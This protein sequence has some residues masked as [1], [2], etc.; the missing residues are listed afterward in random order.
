MSNETT[1]TLDAAPIKD[2]PA[3]FSGVVDSDNDTHP[4]DFILRSGDGVD[5]HVRKDMLQ[6]LSDF[7]QGMF[8]MPK[9]NDPDEIRRDEKIVLL[10]P[11]SAKILYALLWIAY[12]RQTWSRNPLNE[13]DID[14]IADV[15]AAAN[16]YQF[17]VTER[18]VKEML[19]GP[20]LLDAH[21]HRL[22]AIARLRGLSGLAQKAAL[23]TLR[24]PVSVYPLAFPE[25]DLLPWSTGRK[26]YD[27]HR[28]CGEAASQQVKKAALTRSLGSAE[29]K[30]YLTTNDETGNLFIWWTSCSLNFDPQDVHGANLSTAQ[31]EA[32]KIGPTERALI[33]GCN[34]CSN[35]ADNDLVNFARQLAKDIEASNIDLFERLF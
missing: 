6:I 28:Q 24:S 2:A 11:E 4:A 34:A 10:L 22:F 23:H 14:G 18:L 33:N 32:I 26:L 8:S 17:T 35:H 12:P 16:K 3:P 25:M 1:P 29:V 21:P 9:G 5:F 30:L 13:S 7:F 19:E 15:H 27:F 20:V 31:V